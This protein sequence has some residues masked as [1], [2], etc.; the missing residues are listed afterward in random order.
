VLAAA[1]SAALISVS[2]RADLQIVTKTQGFCCALPGLTKSHAPSARR[3]AGSRLCKTLDIYGKE[4]FY[5]IDRKRYHWS[6]LDVL[7]VKTRVQPR[8]SYLP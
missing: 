7:N 5:V 2:V 8:L 6:P 4:N 3:N 1:Q